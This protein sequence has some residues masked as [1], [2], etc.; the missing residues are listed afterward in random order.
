M[1]WEPSEVAKRIAQENDPEKTGYVADIG[2]GHGREA[3]WLAEQGFLSILVEP[4]KY[5]LGYA[6]KRAKKKRLNVIL[7][8]AVL[9]YLPMC[10]EIV[11]VVD[12]YWTLH[13]IPDEYK[14]ESLKEIY[15]ILKPHGTL[16]STSFGYW[17]DHMMPSSIYPVA[18]KQTFLNLHISAGFKPRG[19]IEERS[20]STVSYEKFWYGIFQKNL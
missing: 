9:P 5:S 19:K 14:L 4:N 15:R 7:I 16:Y 1:G 20:D 18:K 11:D 13:Q 10:S 3:L 12:L 8:N 6:K 2:G 17:E